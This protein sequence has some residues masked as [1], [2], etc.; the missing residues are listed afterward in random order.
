MYR[1]NSGSSL[2]VYAFF[3]PQMIH[4]SVLIGL[5][6][7]EKHCSVQ[8]KRLAWKW[9]KKQQMW[10]KNFKRS[11]ESQENC[12]LSFAQKQNIEKSG[13]SRLLHNAAYLRICI[14]LA[15]EHT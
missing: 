11:A 6:T 10:K 14:N 13:G 9:V 8:V 1:H 12:C 3:F 7:N 4:R 15:L 2:E 5:E